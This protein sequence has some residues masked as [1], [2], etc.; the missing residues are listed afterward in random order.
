MVYKKLCGV[1]LL[2]ITVNDAWAVNL[3][4]P[5]TSKGQNCVSVKT[6]DI[7]QVESELYN[8]DV[9]IIG[10][11][12]E[13]MNVK[14]CPSQSKSGCEFHVLPSGARIKTELSTKN[15]IPDVFYQWGFYETSPT[16]NSKARAPNWNFIEASYL[17][18][19]VDGFDQDIK[20]KGYGVI[21][22]ALLGKN[23][24]LSASYSTISEDVVIIDSNIDATLSLA[25]AGIGYRF[26]ASDTTDLF[27][28]ASYLYVEF[29][30]SY[31]GNS[32]S[33]DDN[34]YGLKLGVRS[35]LTE[36]FEAIA[37]IERAEIDSESET[38]FAVSAYYHFNKQLAIGI[39]Y[40]AADDINMY[41]GNLRLSF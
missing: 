8:V 7:K 41:S 34:G 18:A 39:G 11:C 25:S 15:E 26:G 36:S 19:D 9:E 28:M 31:D 21:G 20:P 22:S 29:E 5:T 10:H 17:S 6:L 30:G 12:I 2:C 32:G 14:V 3:T 35:M 23:V 1:F 24:I 27:V 16:P 37:T 33:Y 4:N 13:K 38:A 40:S